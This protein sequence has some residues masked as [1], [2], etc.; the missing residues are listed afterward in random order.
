MT[1]QVPDT[2]KF[3]GRNYIV[4]GWEGDTG[5]IP[6]SESLGLCTVM[7]TT[8][9]WSGRIDHYGVW[10]NELYLFKIE[11][12]LESPADTLT[13]PNA[14]REILLRYEQFFDFEGRPTQLREYRQDFFIY[15]DLKLPFSGCIIVERN[16]NSWTK[17]EAAAEEEAQAAFVIEL[18]NG[19]VADVYAHE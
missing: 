15:E 12:T 13:P 16:E 9:N 2:I 11:V 1:V 3:E 8:A 19:V 14:R 10:G 18:R 6:S 5:C 4:L 17:P 7:E